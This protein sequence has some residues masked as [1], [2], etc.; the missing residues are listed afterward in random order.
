MHLFLPE[1]LCMLFTRPI[2]ILL[3]VLLPE[4]RACS[5]S[6]HSYC[7]AIPY[8][9]TEPK[10]LRRGYDSVPRGT[11]QGGRGSFKGTKCHTQKVSKVPEGYFQYQTES[12]RSVS[13][14]NGNY[15]FHYKWKLEV[16]PCW[17]AEAGFLSRK[18]VTHTWLICAGS[19]TL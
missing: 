19:V 1:R 11:T 7:C 14:I 12:S 15:N 6:H 2:D 5:Y 8:L 9:S 3:P 17:P 13:I 10:D 18:G 4:L 16:A